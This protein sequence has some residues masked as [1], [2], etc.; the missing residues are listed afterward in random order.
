MLHPIT[1]IMIKKYT[2][3]LLLLFLFQVYASVLISYKKKK[4]ITKSI[5]PLDWFTSEMVT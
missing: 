5:T 1:K 3:L 2:V 4:Y